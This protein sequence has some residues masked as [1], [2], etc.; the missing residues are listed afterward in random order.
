M[1]A[2]QRQ[3]ENLSSS[4]C[5]VITGWN[6]NRYN[7]MLQMLNIISLR[8]GMEMYFITLGNM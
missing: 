6:V 1:D 8:E 7:V 4:R 2:K 5:P 3:T